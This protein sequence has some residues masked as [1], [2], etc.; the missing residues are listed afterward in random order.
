M[1]STLWLG[2]LLV[3]CSLTGRC[4]DTPPTQPP[5]NDLTQMNIEDLM[6]IQVTTASKTVQ[7]L[8]DVPAAITVITQEE[9][10]RSGAMNVPEALRMVPG[11]QVAQID[12]NKWAVSIRGFTGRDTNNLLVLIDGRSIYTPLFSGVIWEEQDLPMED[13]DRIEVV[14]GPGGL[15]W[16]SNAVNGVINIITKRAQDTK[17]NLLTASVGNK[18]S[19]SGSFHNGEALG[20]TA[21][22]RVYGQYLTS[23]SSETDKG[24]SAHD[25]WDSARGGFRID[26]DRSASEQIFVEGDAFRKRID[27]A[28]TFPQLTSPYSQT[29]V[30]NEPFSGWDIVGHW[31]QAGDRGA[32]TAVQVYLDQASDNVPTT[33]YS[34]NSMDLDFQR[35]LPTSHGHSLVWGLGYRYGSDEAVPSPLFTFNPAKRYYSLYS[36]FLQDEIVLKHHLRLVLGSKFEHND[37]SGF[38]YQP[39]V[40]LAWTPDARHTLWA[41]IARAV[42]TPARVDQDISV[43]LEAFPGQ[44]GVPTEVALSGNPHAEASTLVAYEMGYRVQPTERVVVDVAAFYNVYR[45]L[46]NEVSGQ[47]IVEQ[48]AMGPYVIVPV[49]YVQN[50]SG[51]TAGIEIGSRYDVTDRWRLALNFSLLSPI[52][53]GD[54]AGDTL[55]SPRDQIGLQSFLNLPHHLEFDTQLSWIDRI[56]DLNVP[57][58]V[59]LDLRLGWKPTRQI[60]LS[61]GVLNLL[62]NRRREYGELY[63]AEGMQIDRTAYGKVAWHF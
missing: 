19:D 1:K 57:G 20:K 11:V 61:A 49:A 62:Y 7:S 13:I 17:G 48:N 37:F 3:S 30:A 21:A 28:V 46:N 25:G 60:E 51:E 47:P 29:V 42:R 45:H 14:R 9:I 4:D 35:Q 44:N 59:R 53:F 39:N 58:Y 43:T 10:R 12:A 27:Q 40:R 36:A 6:K 31:S 24:A 16:G 54:L 15:L 56:P 8:F 55:N 22:Y 2:L 32:K 52:G 23:G 18:E 63:L 26:W 38:E 5:P 33:R 41:S 34:H 50:R